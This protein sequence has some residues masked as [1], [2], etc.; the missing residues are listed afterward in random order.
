M[1]MVEHQVQP[2]ECLAS[3]AKLYGFSGPETLY[4]HEA[5]AQLRKNRPNMHI[6][7]VNDVVYIPPKEFK[8]LP[9]VPGK[10]TVLVLKGKVA[11]LKLKIEEFEGMPLASKAYS[12]VV[13]GLT[14]RGTTSDKGELTQ[15]V[16]AAASQGK[17]SIY[18]DEEQR[19]ALH[20]TLDIGGLQ[21]ASEIA[22]I[23]ARLNNLGYFCA[24]ET[25]ELDTTTQDAIM[26]FKASQGLVVNGQIDTALLESLVAVYGI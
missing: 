9:I 8:Y 3:I 22:G 1:D 18:L 2:G 19:S 15:V 20:W 14:Y 6:L 13:A 23:Q 21:P 11:L 10:N 24:N 4:N 16:D 26:Q 25:G 17:L 12:L 5:N 7:A